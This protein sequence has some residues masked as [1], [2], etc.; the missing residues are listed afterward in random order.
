MKRALPQAIEWLKPRIMEQ[1]QWQKGLQIEAENV[2]IHERNLRE[3]FTRIC[4]ELNGGKPD[5]GWC[6]FRRG[7][8]WFWGNSEHMPE[9]PR[10]SPVTPHPEPA[11][12][13]YTVTIGELLNM[14]SV[15][16]I[17]TLERMSEEQLHSVQT[18]AE[19]RMRKIWAKGVE[20]TDAEASLAD[21][22]E[23]LHDA[24]NTEFERREP[25]VPDDDDSEPV[26]VDEIPIWKDPAIWLAFPIMAK[27][28]P[29]VLRRYISEIEA[30]DNW[31]EDPDMTA[32]WNKLRESENSRLQNLQS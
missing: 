10:S 17:A 7:N 18:D 3:A 13:E 23:L 29:D 2:G 9:A 4:Y 8:R 26:P 19:N 21:R 6:A 12:P 20:Q 28:R 30:Q 22:Y 27:S 31:H 14:T 11:Q 16:Q 15:K 24:I 32:C 25:Y 5:G 1:P